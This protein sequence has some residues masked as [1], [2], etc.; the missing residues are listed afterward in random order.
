[1]SLSE[2]PGMTYLFLME[3]E[4]IKCSRQL[5]ASTIPTWTTAT[6]FQM[7]HSLPCIHSQSILPAASRVTV[8]EHRSDHVLWQLS[9][10]LRTGNWGAEE[11]GETENLELREQDNLKTRLDHT[12]SSFIALSHRCPIRPCV[13]WP[14]LKLYCSLSFRASISSCFLG[15]QLRLSAMAPSPH[16]PCMPHFQASHPWSL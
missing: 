6:S 9:I 16:C 2:I 1:M 14:H 13:F 3:H 10:A 12:W 4:L 8:L 15:P 5:K 11:H 7:A